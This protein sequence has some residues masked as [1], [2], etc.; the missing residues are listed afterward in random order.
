ML[1]ELIRLPEMI[2]Y[3]LTKNAHRDGVRLTTKEM[4][5]EM[6]V[7]QQTISRWMIELEQEGRIARENHEIKITPKTIKEAEQIY[8]ILKIALESDRSY[9]F[10]GAAIDGFGTGALFLKLPGYR[11]GITKKLGFKPFP[12]TLNIKIPADMIDDR[13]SLRSARPITITGFSSGNRHYGTLS[14]YK[15]KIFGEPAAVVFPEMSHH[16]LDVLEI[17]S[18]DNLRERYRLKTGQE[19]ELIVSAGN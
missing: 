1:P 15:A 17:I 18:P 16:G 2:V 14:A 12:G 3:L 5:N 19:V 7:S 11:D 8:G 6:G 4:A 13:L 9:K 10:R